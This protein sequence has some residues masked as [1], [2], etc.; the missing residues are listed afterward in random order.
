M[1][2]RDQL[3]GEFAGERILT[4]AKLVWLA[5]K[6]KNAP[7]ELATHSAWRI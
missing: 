3:L 6:S 4:C 2:D 1:F 5:T 7:N